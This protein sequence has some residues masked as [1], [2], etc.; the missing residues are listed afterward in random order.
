MLPHAREAGQTS[1]VSSPLCGTSTCST[2]FGGLLTTVV[3]LV[4]AGTVKNSLIARD[5]C[6]AAN[7]DGSAFVER[8]GLPFFVSMIIMPLWKR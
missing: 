3:D 1:G 6:T 8:L 5:L 2:S 7:V 4:M